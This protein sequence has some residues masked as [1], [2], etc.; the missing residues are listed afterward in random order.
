MNLCKRGND[1]CGFLRQDAPISCGGNYKKL[2]ILSKESAY[3]TRGF[4]CGGLT[5]FRNYATFFKDKSCD[6]DMLFR[7]DS[8]RGPGW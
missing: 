6:E 1:I 3:V 4:P 8:Q 7:K 2:R 5:F